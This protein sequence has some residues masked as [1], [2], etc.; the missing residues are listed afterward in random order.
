MSQLPAVSGYEVV[1]Q[2]GEGGFGSVFLARQ[3]S[4][5]QLVALKI[6]R[7]DPAKRQTAQRDTERFARE[8][9][10]CAE[11]RHPHIVQLLDQGH[12]EDGRLFA[13][14][15][16]V[17]GESL[18]EYIRRRG[19]LVAPEAGEL[20]AQVL[21]A[22]VCAHAH[23]V[24]HRDLKPQNIMVS[25]TGARPQAKVLDFG[26][27]AVIPSA[28]TSDYKSL[29][30]TN[31][32]IGTPAY[33]APE[34]LRG[35]PPTIKSDLYAWGLVFLE[36]LT[37][38]PAI[39]GA[40]VAEVFHRQLSPAE[41]PLPPAIAG[42]PLGALLRRALKKD[43][44]QR[45]ASSQALWNELQAI[46][47]AN[48]VGEIIGT[49]LSARHASRSPGAELTKTV[50]GAE[51]DSRKHQ[52]TVL[53]CAL[54]PAFGRGGGIDQLE[55]DLEQLE[56]TLR[57]QISDCIDIATRFGG[58]VVG[59]L[60]DRLLVYF[61]YPVATDSDAA[62][63]LRAAIEIK[64]R[65][66]S[67]QGQQQA[68]VRIGIHSGLTVMGAEAVSTGVTSSVAMRLENIAPAGEI[69]VS[70]AVQLRLANTMGFEPFAAGGQ[71]AMGP[72]VGCYRYA[73]QAAPGAHSP[74]SRL[75]QDRPMVGRRDELNAMREA[76]ASAQR[77]AGSL[78]LVT[79]E[80]GIGKSRLVRALLQQSETEPWWCRCLPEQ[81]NSALFPVIELMRSVLEIP[82]VDAGLDARARLERAL[83]AAGVD[84]PRVM[85]IFCVWLSLPLGDTYQPSQLAPPLQKTELLDAIVAWILDRAHRQ[86][87]LLVFEDLHWIDSTSRELLERLAGVVHQHALAVVTT[88]RPEF[89][90]PWGERAR[91]I[92]LSG[93]DSVDIEAMTG[94]VLK[95]RR[96]ASDV[97]R[98]IVARTDGIPLFVEELT[99]MLLDTHLVEAGGELVLKDGTDLSKIP[100]SIRDSLV[101][102]LDRLGPANQT[103]QL[104]A[105]IGREFTRELVVAA[106]ARSREQ[107]EHDLQVLLDADLISRRASGDQERFIF[108]HALIRDA[109]YEMLTSSARRRVHRQIADALEQRFPD[110]V[111]AD[112]GVL[113]RHL[114]EAGSYQSATDHG[115][116]AAMIALQQSASD[117]AISRSHT[118]LEWIKELPEAD[119]GKAE[120]T[121]NS[122]LTPALMNKYGWAAKELG[123][124]ASRSLEILSTTG[125]SPYHVPTLWWVVM[126]RLV[127]GNRGTLA[128]LTPQLRAMAHQ[129]GEA[130]YIAASEALAG[131]YH[132]TQG[133]CEAG[134][135]AMQLAL[136]AYDPQMH[137][138]S[139]AIYGFDTRA[140][141]CASL[142]R[143]TWDIG[144][145][146]RA[147]TL[148]QDAVDWAREINHVPSISIALMY[149]SI[150][151]QYNGEKAQ[152]GKVSGELLEFSA[153]Y[154]L[155][156]YAAYGAMMHCWATGDLAGG[157]ES[158]ALL[159]AIKSLHAVA[160][161]YSL[162]ADID[163]RQGRPE[164]ALARIDR[165]IALCGSVDEHYY[166]PHL[167]LRRAQ[168]VMGAPWYDQA[169]AS[170]DLETAR[171]KATAQGAVRVAELAREA[172]ARH[173]ESA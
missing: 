9:R 67:A 128:E 57:G 172:L 85:P 112:P 46:N 10:L 78:F 51:I 20:M 13:A 161:F 11:L 6:Q 22:L 26:I 152:A 116:R 126:N 93:L 103:A 95:G 115:V 8:A 4:T 136:D 86:P 48:L 138:E 49:P 157:E 12:T 40:S 27:G 62:R 154:G 38:T 76:W 87:L 24:V 18:K 146:Q 98:L 32:L 94:M 71:E 102:R 169:Q 65:F 129:T 122:I 143:V 68:G 75:S 137:R 165:C 96:L 70:D 142:A 2:L 66:S 107:A 119:R 50:H 55:T 80:A 31:E 1:A 135:Q 88:A 170:R 44:A 47:L 58:Y 113:A 104:A 105:A 171:R 100:S 7:R 56:T 28:R 160:Y 16:Y 153:K 64:N 61:G 120:L 159:D 83:E 41:V 140:F 63:A 60:A 133:D 39:D 73:D 147:T 52:I 173:R 167:Y 110:A 144:H 151:H 21:D 33:S 79:G 134:R 123:D 82:R 145:C 19:P 37:G 69:L 131:Y 155:K 148:A 121:V 43:A 81:M 163:L 101:G 130:A 36:C 34:Q 5:R 42:H 72:V 111:R 125:D 164:A 17:P 54:P 109:A 156:V 141:A 124:T 132:Y 168:Y 77:A 29:T 158:F 74:V 150:V 23:G 25:S 35:E 84:L 114:F 59:T 90:N 15:Q 92:A 30:L 45:Y 3:H 89:E 118:L 14:Y 99:R 91:V 97:V 117:E 149:Q 108:R 106:A 162:L 139:G 166:E 53:C 127:A